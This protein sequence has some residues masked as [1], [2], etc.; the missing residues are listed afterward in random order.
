MISQA[1]KKEC[2]TTIFEELPFDVVLFV[3]GF[4][5]FSFPTLCRLKP[6]CKRW[7]QII[8]RGIDTMSLKK[9]FLTNQ[10]LCDAVRKH[11]EDKTK[12]AEELARTYGWPIGKW[13]VSQVTDFSGIFHNMY[14]F[15]EGI[16]DWDVSNGT[17]FR[18]M[19]Y[20]ATS[21]NQKLDKWNVSH[22]TNME[23]MF[24]GAASFDRNLS[25]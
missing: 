5:P 10:E 19:F 1:S 15:N 9:P 25:K 8:D 18:F 7:M 14:N 21:F 6:V 16:K 11:A 4:A 22:A 3:F 13:D 20:D 23:S 2:I 17:N 24:E 12:F